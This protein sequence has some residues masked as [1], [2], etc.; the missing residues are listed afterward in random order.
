MTVFLLGAGAASPASAQS[1]WTQQQG[2]AS[3]TGGK[4]KFGL[5]N[6]FLGWTAMF[7]EAK[8]PQHSAEWKGFAAGMPQSLFYTAGGILQ[9]V[10]FPLP[11]DF[12]DMG[13]GLHIPGGKT[14]PRT[15]PADEKDLAIEEALN[16]ASKK[17]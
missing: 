17:P 10:T 9:L 6:T 16:A 4:L 7:I 14:E 15:P 13:R 1:S 8:Q 12:P 3:Q 5:V 2:Y 11:M